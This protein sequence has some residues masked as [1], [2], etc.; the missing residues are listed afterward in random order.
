MDFQ[1]NSIAKKV[2]ESI[3]ETLESIFRGENITPG[4][5]IHAYSFFFFFSLLKVKN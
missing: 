4:Q 2:W 5:F 1:E 3:I